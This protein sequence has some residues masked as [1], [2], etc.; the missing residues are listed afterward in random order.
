MLNDRFN[1]TLHIDLS[2][3]EIKLNQ[4]TDFSQLLIFLFSSFIHGDL[5]STDD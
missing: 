4:Q 2:E 5:P 1:I 3:K